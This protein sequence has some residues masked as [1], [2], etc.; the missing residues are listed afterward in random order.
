VRRTKRRALL[1]V[2]ILRIAAR[3]LERQLHLLRVDVRDRERAQASSS[4]TSDPRP[5]G[6]ARHRSF[7]TA[8][9]VLR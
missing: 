3:Q 5:V 8:A 4:T 6:D 1:R 2:G 7:A 9:S